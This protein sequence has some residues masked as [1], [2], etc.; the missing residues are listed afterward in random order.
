MISLKMFQMILAV[1]T[2]FLSLYYSYKK[3]YHKANYHLGLSILLVLVSK[4][5]N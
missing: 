4:L 2:L 1:I 3:D 5:W